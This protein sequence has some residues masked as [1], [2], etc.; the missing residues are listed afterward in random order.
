MKERV[1]LADLWKEIKDQT[2]SGKSIEDK[3]S[4]EVNELKQAKEKIYDSLNR[5]KELLNKV[6]PELGITGTA[7]IASI[8]KALASLE[9]LAGD[10]KATFDYSEEI[11][12]E[13]NYDTN[14]NI[15]SIIR[16][17]VET[18]SQLNDAYTDWSNKL[19]QS[20]QRVEELKKIDPESSR[21]PEKLRD[22]SELV[23]SDDDTRLICNYLDGL[24]GSLN[25]LRRYLIANTQSLR[26]VLKKINKLQEAQAENNKSANIMDL[27]RAYKD[28]HYKV[29]DSL[30]TLKDCLGD[31]YDAFRRI[32]LEP[33]KLTELNLQDAIALLNKI[34]SL[35][36]QGPCAEIKRFE[37]VKLS[38]E[39]RS[40]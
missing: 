2:E 11:T 5:I 36:D 21:F 30:G 29:E 9:R 20:K 10:M 16:S 32:V 33:T 38:L 22:I 18:K 35:P 12:L 26:A 13:P 28:L 40:S 17:I 6:G 25:D 34:S 1:T 24:Y 8:I 19:S 39:R 23:P 31:S 14:N 37:K 15:L 3:I 27:L 7:T 4:A